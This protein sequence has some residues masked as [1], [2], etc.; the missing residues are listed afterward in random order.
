[1]ACQHVC[2]RMMNTNQCSQQTARKCRMLLTGNWLWW[3]R[4]SLACCWRHCRSRNNSILRYPVIHPVTTSHH[5]AWRSQRRTNAKIDEY[6][7]LAI[8]I[9]LNEVFPMELNSR[10]YAWMN[11]SDFLSYRSASMHFTPITIGWMW[12][13]LCLAFRF[14]FFFLIFFCP[15]LNILY[16]WSIHTHS[17]IPA[18]WFIRSHEKIK[19][20]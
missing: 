16:I 4:T 7:R 9:R 19:K 18:S 2:T 3:L 6:F 20:N 5:G 15:T 14:T 8:L 12:R 10:Y 13:D 1:M 17:V 11:W